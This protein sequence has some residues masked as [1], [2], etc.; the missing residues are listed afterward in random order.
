M[1]TEDI[2]AS[3][4][5]GDLARFRE[6]QTVDEAKKPKPVSQGPAGKH[7]TSAFVQRCVAAMTSS[8]EVD[9][10]KKGDLGRAFAICTAAQ[11]KH[12]RFAKEKA[13]E[14]V[15]EVRVK[16]FEKALEQGREARAEE[17]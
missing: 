12:P 15:P 1:N 16:E 8:G 7:H 6:Q 4:L 11:K 13:K 10:E 2:K 14:G 17:E 9:A 5:R 3:R